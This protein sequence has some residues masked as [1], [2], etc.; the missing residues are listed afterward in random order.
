MSKLVL[1]LKKREEQGKNQV[2]KLRA[3]Q[4]IPGVIYS[5]GNEAVSVSAVEKELLKVYETAGTS[6]IVNIN[7]N[8]E[9][10]SVLF[11][12]IQRHPFKNQILHFDLY[13]VDMSEK[14]R[15]MIPIVLEGRDE[16]RIQP[17]VLMQ[18]IDEIEIE[19]LPSKLPS[20]AIYNV[21]EMQIGDTVS[22]KDLDVFNNS[23]VEVLTDAEEIVAV[24]QEPK[25]EVIEE[26]DGEVSVEVPTVAETNKDE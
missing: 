9:T 17:S 2:D 13:L 19:C 14:L 26:T 4:L 6:N 12:E 25:E 7:L 8:G 10:K 18:Q 24:L 20:E 3:N 16:I 11:K 15:V 21:E 1:D 5:K 23:D 22:V